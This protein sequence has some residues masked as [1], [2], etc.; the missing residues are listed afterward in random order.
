MSHPRMTDNQR[1]Y[2]LDVVL[3]FCTLVLQLIDRPRPLVYATTIAL[4]DGVYGYCTIIFLT[5]Q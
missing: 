5:S 2:Y 4:I 3:F 1:K